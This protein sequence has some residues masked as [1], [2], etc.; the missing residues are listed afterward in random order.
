MK[1]EVD[2]YR[3]IIGNKTCVFEKEDDPTLMRAPSAGKLLNYL[4][5]DGGRVIRNQPYAEIEVMKMVGGNKVIQ[6][7]QS[8]IMKWVHFLH[9]SLRE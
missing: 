7:A 6:T 5:E 2:R 9:Q 3:I 4:V 1:E 8:Q